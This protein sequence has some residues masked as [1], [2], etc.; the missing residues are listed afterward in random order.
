MISAAYC[1]LASEYDELLGDLAE[2]TWRSGILAELARLRTGQGQ[3]VID[4]GAGTGTGGRLMGD[5]G[6]QHRRIGVDCSE[7][8]L[9]GAAGRYEATIVADIAALPAGECCADFIVSGFDTLNYLSPG[10]FRRCLAGAAR[11][12]KPGGW[13]VFDYSSPELLRGTWRDHHHDQQ[14]PDGVLRWRHR[15]DAAAGRSVSSIERHD[16]D[17]NVTWR[18]THVQYA[19]DAYPLHEAAVAAGLRAEWVRDLDRP[20]FSPTAG[21]HVWVLRKETHG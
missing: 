17:G 10:Q 21:T 16:A 5:A 13:L 12:L 7:R 8:M 18:E 1:S 6:W 3:V 14:L 20:E 19:L 2:A 4:L 15:Y 11:C 9:R